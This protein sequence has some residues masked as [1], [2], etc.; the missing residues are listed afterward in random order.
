MSEIRQATAIVSGTGAEVVIGGNSDFAIIGE[1]INP[2][3]KAVLTKSIKDGEFDIPLNSARKQLE[4]GAAVID[5]N[6]GA[7]GVD[8]KAV[9]PKLVFYLQENID[10]P[11][12][13]DSASIDALEAAVNV[14]RGRPII[15][16]TTGEPARLSRMLALTKACKGTLIALLMDEKGIPDDVDGRMRIADRILNEATRAG[17]SPSNLLIDCVVMSVGA[18][19]RAG[20]TT[21]LTQ[22]QVVDKFKVATV[23]GVSNVSH[24]MPNR[25][26]LNLAMLSVAVFD[27]LSAAIMDPMDESM[28][29]A[30][31]ACRLLAGRDEMGMEYVLHCRRS[32][33]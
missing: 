17:L 3:N 10:A 25:P 29:D 2:T 30:V 20:R 15:N 9:L 22:R 23:L 14:Y 7:A 11:L 1:R 16:S 28:R 8:E 31:P 6:V 12:S 19:P 4:A 21:L 13:L 32:K 26:V 5:V 33:S 27:G 24:G 18:S